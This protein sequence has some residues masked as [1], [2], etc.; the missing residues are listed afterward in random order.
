M[1]NLGTTDFIDGLPNWMK[2]AI[3]ADF[4]GPFEMFNMGLIKTTIPPAC[5]GCSNHPSMGGSGI[6][7]CTLGGM[8]T[9]C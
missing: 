9:T 4:P 7:H 3:M 1:G 8:A 6:C 2:E 5:Q